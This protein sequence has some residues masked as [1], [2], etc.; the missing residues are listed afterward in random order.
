MNHNETLKDEIFNLLVLYDTDKE[1]IVHFS[2][3]RATYFRIKRKFF[4]DMCRIGNS[5][6]SY[7]RMRK[8]YTKF[9]DQSWLKEVQN[10]RKSYGEQHK[11]ERRV[12]T[13]LRDA[14]KAGKVNK[15]KTCEVC[16]RDRRIVGHHKDYEQPLN[17]VWCC[18]G[19]HWKLHNV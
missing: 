9:V 7:Y 1:R 17:V 18:Q 6:V 10:R 2:K 15:P 3:S 14:V 5:P 12:H 16:G 8:V 13:I 19:C 11:K 4:S